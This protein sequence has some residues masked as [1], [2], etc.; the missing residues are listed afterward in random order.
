MHVDCH[1]ATT[2]IVL[3][4]SARANT[5]NSFDAS[6][7]NFVILKRSHDNAPADIVQD[8]ASA[9]NVIVANRCRT[10][11]PDGLCG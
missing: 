11:V 5:D 10:S 8:Q 2:W 6:T 3:V 1:P 9:P 7:H 4:A